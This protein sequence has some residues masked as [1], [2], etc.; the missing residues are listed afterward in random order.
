MRAHGG[1]PLHEVFN[2]VPVFLTVGAVS[3][4]EVPLGPDEVTRVSSR[5]IDKPC[6]AASNY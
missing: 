1:K 3:E 5:G 2:S 4:A 6:V